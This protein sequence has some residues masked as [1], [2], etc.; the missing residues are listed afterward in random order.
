MDPLWV[1]SIQK[2]CEQS[3]VPFFFKQWAAFIRSSLAAYSTA[4]HGMN[5]LDI[6]ARD[7]GL[8]VKPVFSLADRTEFGFLN[9]CTF[10]RENQS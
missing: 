10:W 6:P 5:H 1:T 2:Q 7:N 8:P 9:Q 3:H 4:A